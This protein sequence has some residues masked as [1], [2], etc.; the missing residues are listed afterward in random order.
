MDS[1]VQN[2]DLFKGLNICRAVT[3]L[4]GLIGNILSF[5]I[6][7]RPTFSKNSIGIYCRALAIFDCYTIIEL[8]S[9]LTRIF[10]DFF[11]PAHS[12]F[13]CK[14]FFYFNVGFSSIPG[15]ILVIFSFDKMISMRRTTHGKFEFLKKPKFQVWAIVVIVLTNLLIYSEVPILLNIFNDSN[16]NMTSQV[17]DC[18]LTYMP[19]YGLVDAFYLFEASVIPFG[20]MI[21]TSVSIVRSIRR[22]RKMLEKTMKRDSL[23]MRERK[24]RDVKFAVTSLALNVLFV[25]LKLPIVFYYLLTFY[26]VSLSWVVFFLTLELFYVNS[27]IPIFVHLASNWLFRKELRILL[28]LEATNRHDDQTMHSMQTMHMDNVNVVANARTLPPV[29]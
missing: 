7:S 28:G 3:I 12:N 17:P 5:I 2:S 24:S 10:S 1:S 21:F 13:F 9:D 6:F 29:E 11:I 18:D 26:G 19:F 22:S 20:L 14:V 27:A 16:Q 8:I 4:I 23:I 15:W 25:V